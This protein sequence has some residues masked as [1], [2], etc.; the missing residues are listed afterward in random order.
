MAVTAIVAS[1]AST[2]L[3]YMQGKKQEAAQ[4]KQLAAQEAANTW[5]VTATNTA[6]S[7]RLTDGNMIQTAVRSR[8]A[9]LIWT[10]TALYQCSLLVLLLL[11]DLNNLDQIVV[12]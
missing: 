8:G 6:G 4:K 3:S 10:D 7:K 11:L 2:G 9:V 12:V 1:V 5:T